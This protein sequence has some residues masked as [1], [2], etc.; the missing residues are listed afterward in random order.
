VIG[1]PLNRKQSNTFSKSKSNVKRQQPEGATV[2]LQNARS[3]DPGCVPMKRFEK[4][5]AS[6]KDATE[7]SVSFL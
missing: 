1:K 6:G 7:T 5:L 2:W 3:F 4:L